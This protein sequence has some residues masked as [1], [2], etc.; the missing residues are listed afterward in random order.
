MHRPDLDGAT[1][2]PRPFRGP[3]RIWHGSA[4]STTAVDLAAKWGEPQRP[5]RPGAGAVLVLGPGIAATAL[6][7]SSR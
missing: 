5:P 4:T 1:T 2:H 6:A 7:P 3:F